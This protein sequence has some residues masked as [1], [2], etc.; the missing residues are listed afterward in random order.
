MKLILIAVFALLPLS[1]AAQPIHTHPQKAAYASPAE[2]PTLSGDCW[3]GFPGSGGIQG[4]PSHVGHMTFLGFPFDAEI[5]GP[6]TTRFSIT[7]FNAFGKVT[8][9]W[10]TRVQSWTLDAGQTLPLIADP[11]GVKTWTGTV[12]FAPINAP[13][14][15]WHMYELGFTTLM[16]NGV[17]VGTSLRL[18][19][20]SMLDPTAPE[21]GSGYVINNRCTADALW[22]TQFTEF[23]QRLPILGPIDP[24]KPFS[25]LAS[26]YNY[27]PLPFSMPAGVGEAWLNPDNH[28]GN[29]GTLLA[30]KVGPNNSPSQTELIYT[31]PEGIPEG[32]HKVLFAW[33]RVNMAGDKELVSN[34]VFNIQVGT[35]GGPP[36]PPP[37]PDPCVADPLV[38]PPSSA[39]GWPVDPNVTGVSLTQI[40]RNCPPIEV[41]R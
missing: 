33:K 37:P 15:G 29:P 20:Y 34:L 7:T 4:S 1:V 32:Q 41:P 12:T 17:P 26:M 31:F 13:P 9:L 28:N 16:A 18:P 21:T 19:L 23:K 27:A 5:T 36:P 30:M 38:P 3:Y 39:F 14:R 25:V 10:G 22:G 35:G 40:G 2:W 8:G 6:F 11:N 24:A